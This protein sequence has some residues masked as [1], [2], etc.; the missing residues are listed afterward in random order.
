M[1]SKLDVGKLETA[2]VDLSKLSDVVKIEVVKKTEYSEL[3]RKVNNINTTDTSD[4]VKNTDHNT[5]IMQL[6]RK[7]LITIMLNTLLLKK[8]VSERFPARL[9]QA[10]LARK[11]DI[12]ALVKKTDLD[13]SIKVLATIAKL[14]AKQGKMKKKNICKDIQVLLSVK[15]TLTMMELKII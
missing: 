14:K 4:L 6:K 2:A 8:L 13:E 5:K 10:N 7:L 9:A 11:N 3:V 12:V 15:I 1:K